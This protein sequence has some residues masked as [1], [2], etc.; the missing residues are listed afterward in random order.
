VPLGKRA[1]P[2]ISP[3]SQVEEEMKESIL[4]LVTSYE[5]RISMLEELVSSAYEAVATSNGSPATELEKERER[6]KTSLQET[7]A[8]NCCLRRK[9]FNGLIERV[10]SDSEREKKEIEEEQKTAR[11]KLKEYLN[12]QKELATSLRE[13]LVEFA[14]ENA[15]KNSLEVAIGDIKAAHQAKGEQVLL[16]LR[17]FQSHLEIFQR[18]G[19]EINHKL[20]RLVERGET[21]KVEDLR[22]LE[23]AKARQ[24]RKAEKELRRDDVERLLAHF[25]QERQRSS[26]HS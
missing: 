6:L 16:L 17:N 21:L 23:A 3:T 20:R 10:L 18:E 25:R 5:N 9:D 4:E 7:L 14:E 1:L 13:Q 22:Q 8:K 24:A 19:T 12:E 11:E 2:N 15:N 26:H